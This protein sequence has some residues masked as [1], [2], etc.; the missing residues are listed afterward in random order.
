MLIKSCWINGCSLKVG[1]KLNNSTTPQRKASECVQWNAF[2][3]G[4]PSNGL[5]SIHYI[6]FCLEKPESKDS[7]FELNKKLSKILLEKNE[8]FAYNLKHP[9]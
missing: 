8:K 6:N 2:K 1:I 7:E 5:C 9:P 3:E 4:V